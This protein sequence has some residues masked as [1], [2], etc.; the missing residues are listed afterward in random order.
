MI[1]S[2]RTRRA[3]LKA[4]AT[5]NRLVASCKRRPRSIATHLIAAGVDAQT[6]S[7]AASGMKAAAK[8]IGLAPAQ[9]ARTRRTTA[10]G[11]ARITRT[12]T[13][14][15]RNQLRR[16]LAAYNPRKAEYRAAV[17]R[18]AAALT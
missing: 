18:L 9:V 11:R 14:W 17:A 3:A 1:D 2:N 10:G 7:G 15:T 13:R 6:A 4:R 8:R 5:A 12:V 16:L